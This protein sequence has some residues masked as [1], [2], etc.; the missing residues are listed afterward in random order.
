MAGLIFIGDEMI[1][2]EKLQ[3]SN[4]DTVMAIWLNTNINAH[5]FIPKTYWESNYNMVKELIPKSDVY[6]LQYNN[7]IAAF[8]GV[9][10]GY[11][12]GLFVNSNYQSKGFGKAL[13][14]HIKAIYTHLHLEVYEKNKRAVL[15]YKREGFIIT[16]RFI[17]T[18]VNEYSY[19]ME[20]SKPL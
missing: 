7:S 15:F 2:I 17:D 20:W 5:S 3:K 14:D 6:L 12:A 13:L 16:E 1:N 18:S 11:I 10:D 8:I 4:L 19:K 9:L